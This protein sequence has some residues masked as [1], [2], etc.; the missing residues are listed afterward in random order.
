MIALC[1]S[2]RK[3]TIVDRLYTNV[4]IFMGTHTRLKSAES[5]GSVYDYG[6]DYG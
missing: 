6:D 5:S 2:K 4:H 1:W 3:T